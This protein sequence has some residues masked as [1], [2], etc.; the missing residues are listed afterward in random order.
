MTAKD[1]YSEPVET[2]IPEC[3]TEGQV[4]LSSICIN[5]AYSILTF[6]QMSLDY[7]GNLF[8][9]LSITSISCFPVEQTLVFR[10]FDHN[11]FAGVD[12]ELLC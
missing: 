8:I 7:N 6:L 12:E 4:A 11:G 2:A 9:Q 5:S 3:G 10:W 1:N